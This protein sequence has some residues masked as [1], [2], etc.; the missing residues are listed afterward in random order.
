MVP[1]Q[2]PG[3]TIETIGAAS[4]IAANNSG[5]GLGP[6][7]LQNSALLKQLPLKLSW[8]EMLYAR[9]QDI[10]TTTPNKF[11]IVA[12]LSR[13][14]A[15]HT[16]HC[17]Q[18]QRLFITVGGDHSCAIGTWS[19]VYSALQSRA[20]NTKNAKTNALGLLWIDAHMDSHTPATTPSGNIHGMPLACLLGYGDKSLTTIMETTPKLKPENICLVGVRSY[21]EGEAELLKKLGVK[22]FF[23]PDIIEQGLDKVMQQALE[24]ISKNTVGYGVSID[25]DALDPLYAPGVGVPEPNGISAKALCENL[26][27]LQLHQDPRLLGIE[28][29]EFNPNLD[30]EHKTEQVIADILQAIFVS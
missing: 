4:G 22:I 10:A 1:T 3:K 7:I 2:N 23:M 13:R 14:I 15:E 12:D 28:I 16:Y 8:Q 19:G 24:I 29:V 11:E 21:E 5:C 20:K 26:H 25:L 30:Q 9:Q 27:A 6:I 17:T 18:N